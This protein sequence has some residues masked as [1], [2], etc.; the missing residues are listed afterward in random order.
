MAFSSSVSDEGCDAAAAVA[1]AAVELGGAV[2]GSKAAE[3]GCSSRG[4][5]R[6]CNPAGGCGCGND[7]TAPWLTGITA[8]AAAAGAECCRLDDV[9]PFMVCAL[10][11]PADTRLWTPP[12]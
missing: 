4:P 5:G 8:A 7:S 2:G 1:V 12:A 11:A 9:M 6:Y 10:T 3:V